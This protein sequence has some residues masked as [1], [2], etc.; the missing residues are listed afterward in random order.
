M[1]AL[2]SN[3]CHRNTPYYEYSINTISKCVPLK[4]SQ[5]YSQRIFMIYS[6]Q[7]HS[8]KL[9]RFTRTITERIIGKR[10]HSYIYINIYDRHIVF[11]YIH[12][13]FTNNKRLY[14]IGTKL[15]PN[16][17][18]YEAEESNIYVFLYCCK[19]QECVEIIYRLIFY[20]VT[21]ILRA[22]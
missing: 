7:T 10:W 12:K 21:L 17:D 22:P 18:S 5:I 15:S 6:I 3:Y 4:D 9:R 2:P 8:Q 19:L 16:C 11:N 13:I 20:F 14:N 1:G